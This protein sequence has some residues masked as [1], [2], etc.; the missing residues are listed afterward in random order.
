MPG[1]PTTGARIAAVD[2]AVPSSDV[3][4]SSVTAMDRFDVVVVGSLNLDLVARAARLPGPGETVH[5]SDF[6]EVAGGKGLNQAVAAARSGARVAMIGAIGDDAAGGAL[7]RVLA[8]DGVDDGGV[9]TVAGVPTGRALIAV[10]ESAENSIV[11]VS[12]ANAHVALGELPESAVVLAQMEIDPGVV[13]AAFR[14]ARERGATTVLNPAPAE[15]VPEELLALCDVVVP[16][17]HELAVLGGVERLRS[18]GVGTLI[19]TRGR[20]G[21]DLIE[22]DAEP[23]HV[24]AFDVT[25]VDTTGAGDACCGALS[26]RLAAGD[27]L[28]RALVFGAAAGALATTVA[29]A[30]PSLPTA[31]QVRSLVDGHEPPAP[32]PPAPRVPRRSPAETAVEYLA[33][34]GTGDP[35]RVAE[36]VT[37]DFVNEH[38]SALGA[39]CVGRDEYRRRLPGFLASMPGLHYEVE[40]IVADGDTVAAPYVLTATSDGS[41]VRLRGVMVIDTRDGLVARRT[42]YWDALTFLRQTGHA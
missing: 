17:E 4:A 38:A 19:V 11:V 26:A 24:P 2:L 10:D 5:G 41:P 9:R 22:P 34:F 33:A 15:S 37:D 13:I 12:G 3:A 20:S 36:L 30:V 6:A 25:P 7:R 40:Q 28:H 35:E 21:A 42:D 29:G 23:V 14:A 39:G 16:N 18:L 32:A 31:E 27:P 8:S 1:P